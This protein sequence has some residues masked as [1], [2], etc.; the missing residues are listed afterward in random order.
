MKEVYSNN[1]KL[2]IV[3]IYEAREALDKQEDRGGSRHIGYFLNQLDAIEASQGMGAMG[4]ASTPSKH[5]MATTDGITGFLAYNR[6]A[7]RVCTNPEEAKKVNA[8]SK[9]TDEDLKVLGLRRDL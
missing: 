1:G 7:V 4:Y 3:E 5:Y 8:L 2:R 9:L 6:D